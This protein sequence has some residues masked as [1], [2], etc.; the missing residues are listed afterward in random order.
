MNMPISALSSA[1]MGIQAS[2]ARM[3][4]A[5]GKIA[6]FALDVSADVPAPMQGA[7]AA[8][9][10]AVP[11]D[12]LAGAMVDMIIAQRSFAAQ[13]R[14]LETADEMSGEAIN[15]GQHRGR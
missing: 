11:E 3:D 7:S 5:A 13:L 12:D 4:R 10:A 14:V 15:I 1:R 6:R 9:D 2:M 8:S